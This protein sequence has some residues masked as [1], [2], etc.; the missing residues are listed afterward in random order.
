MNNKEREIMKKWHKIVLIAIAVLVGLAITLVILGRDN[1]SPEPEDTAK[2]MFIDLITEDVQNSEDITG[3]M[4][5]IHS[6]NLGLHETFALDRNATGSVVNGDASTPFHIASI[7]KT[8]TAVL[9]AKLQESGKLSFND[10]ISNYLSP[11]I[12]KGLFVYQ[13]VDYQS[14]VTIQQ[15]LGHTSGVADY[16]EDPV[17]SGKSMQELVLADP[18][19][20]WT[21]LELLSFSRDNQEVFNKPGAAFH[22]SDTGYVLLGLIIEK[23]TN[24][25][26]DKNMADEIFTPL[27]MDDSYLM[28]YSN[29]KNMPKKEIAKIWFNG[30]EAS[31]FNSLSIDWAGGGIVS[32]L[33]DLLKFHKALRE[34]ELISAQTLAVMEMFDNEYIPGIHYGLGMMQLRFEE[35]SSL[36][37][38]YPRMTGNM[39]T[40]ST[41]M[42]YDDVDETY[43]VMNF[44]SNVHIE[45]AVEDLIGIV[46]ILASIK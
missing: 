10:N 38:G 28:F 43:V 13:G 41:L 26:F 34:G 12:L 30:T 44:G 19:R 40:I 29:P 7:G 11:E 17:R 37:G 31:K 45:K 27:Q 14:K 46:Q 22:Y 18:N 6:D 39:G 25:S 20:L 24:K 15:L 36:L 8:F 42:F 9:V 21:P 5:L 1:S 2:K 32:T 33:D 35:F 3:A 23:V 4:V 16:W